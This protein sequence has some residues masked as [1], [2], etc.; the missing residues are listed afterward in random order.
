MGMIQLPQDFKEFLKLLNSKNV[1]YLIVGGYAVGLYGYPRAT[2]DMDIWIAVNEPNASRVFEIVKE[3]GFNIPELTES[4]F[5]QKDKVIRMGNPPLRIEILTSVSGID[6][7]KSYQNRKIERIEGIPINF[8]GLEDL[9]KNKK[10]SGRHKD[11]D[12]V[13]HLK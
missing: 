11:L 2:G 4:V 1:E 12:D 7:E 8:I 10:A 5:A 3:F 6:F 9:I 13:E